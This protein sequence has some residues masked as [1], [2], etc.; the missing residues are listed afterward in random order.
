M[1]ETKSQIDPGVGYLQKRWIK[2]AAHEARAIELAMRFY[3]TEFPAAM[4]RALHLSGNSPSNRVASFGGVIAVL[5]R[6]TDE[7]DATIADIGSIGLDQD[8]VGLLD[9]LS[10]RDGET[11][12]ET[13]LRAVI[14]DHV[15]NLLVDLVGGGFQLWTSPKTA[16]PWWPT[17][18]DAW[19]V[20]KADLN[21]REALEKEAEAQT[22]YHYTLPKAELEAA[23]VP[24][25][26]ANAIKDNLE[27]FT[28]KDY[29]DYGDYKGHKSYLY[30]HTR[31]MR[32]DLAKHL[33]G[34][35]E[36]GVTPEDYERYIE[37]TSL[38]WTQIPEWH[39][40]GLTPALAAQIGNDFGRSAEAVQ[41]AVKLTGGPER[42]KYFYV[43]IKGRASDDH[44][45]ARR[46]DI[47]TFSR[48]KGKRRDVLDTVKRVNAAWDY[49]VETCGSV[50]AAQ[51]WLDLLR[52]V[53][54]PT[55][56]GVGGYA[57]KQYAD[58]EAHK[59]V[60]AKWDMTDLPMERIEL[61]I[62]AGVTD[63]DEALQEDTAALTN[64]QL[65]VAA[66]MN[67]TA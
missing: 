19:D 46:V 18:K 4:A 49:M 11:P 38:T 48:W 7:T 28:R 40:A 34:M 47:E 54:S 66:M 21:R 65:N 35:Y 63:P 10:A 55:K 17:H 61:L 20:L 52:I 60:I 64:E 30:D 5:H 9:A 67:A 42:L 15:A 51:R 31:V 2:V 37:N 14:N 39:S 50:D 16:G 44:Q 53:P 3:G 24:P 33:V 57:N 29:R 41:Q 26:W 13:A 8:I 1:P 32:I 27:R 59:I 36:A 25:A 43:W 45:V 58:P 12:K 62:K 23:N 56:P 6:L 22:S